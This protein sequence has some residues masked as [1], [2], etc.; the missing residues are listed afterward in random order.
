MSQTSST[1]GHWIVAIGAVVIVGA[2]MLQWWQIGGGPGELAERTG[3][4]IA[5]GRVFLM[6]VAAVVTLLLATLPFASERPIAIDHPLA[7]LAL[8]AILLGAYVWRVVAMAQG[9]LVPWP[10]QR[11]FGFWLAA[12]GLVMFSRG[13][14][15]MFEE[16]R[17]RLY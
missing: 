10:P 12:I 8:F 1:R 17:R 16:R 15:E 9:S 2:A 11:G 4:G 13:V 3:T 7:Y 6:F 5:D 14:F